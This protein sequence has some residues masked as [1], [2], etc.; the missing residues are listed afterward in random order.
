MVSKYF[1]FSDRHLDF[2]WNAASH[3]VG[4]YT[5]ENLD[6]ENMGIDTG[7]MPVSRPVQELQF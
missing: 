1:R 7:I 6:P 5:V 3:N 2:Q 4:K